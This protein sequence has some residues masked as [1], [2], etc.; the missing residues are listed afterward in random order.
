M[1]NRGVNLPYFPVP[2]A[3]YNQQYFSELVRSFSTY[4][5][6][7]NNPGVGRQTTM[8]LTALPTSTANLRDGDL[9]N[10][11]GF[12]RIHSSTAGSNSGSVLKVAMFED[13]TDYTNATSVT[14]TLGS[15]TP[16][17]S[18]NAIIGICSVNAGYAEDS[19]DPG[20]NLAVRYTDSGGTP[21]TIVNTNDTTVQGQWADG[22]SN[23]MRGTS[24]AFFQLDPMQLDANGD[25]TISFVVTGVGGTS[26]STLDVYSQSLLIMEVTT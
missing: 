24:T 25:V 5:Q 12:V 16:L 7:M 6:N 11:N 10:E 13:N 14:T 8:A 2:P 23:I 21:T 9:Y 20:Y 1:S 19:A 15:Y 17:N 18:A 4:L 22:G 3:E 26:N